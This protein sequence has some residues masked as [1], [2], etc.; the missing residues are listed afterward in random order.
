MGQPA[1]SIEMNRL[2]R[3]YCRSNRWKRKLEA[4]ILPWSLE[5]VR[6]GDDVLEV[7]PGPGLTTDWLRH[8]CTGLTCL[9]L[10]QEL[11]SSLARRTAGNGIRVDRGDGAAMPYPDGSFSTVVLFT[12]LHHVP[13]AALQDRLFSETYRVLKPGGTFAR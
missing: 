9:E 1:G 8:R 11:A 12:V 5:G 13:S 2:H 3:W 7:G 10:D 4:E 6:L